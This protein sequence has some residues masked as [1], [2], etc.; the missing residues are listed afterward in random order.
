[1]CYVQ[2][3]GDTATL[4]AGSS[5]SP[6][7]G[8]SGLGPRVQWLAQVPVGALVEVEMLAVPGQGQQLVEVSST[9]AGVLSQR[10]VYYRCTILP[11]HIQCTH[12]DMLTA[13]A[14]L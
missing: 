12:T 1:M 8:V 9:A 7:A 3:E 5:S 2:D 6:L 14:A 13:V 11:Y 4:Q 10:L